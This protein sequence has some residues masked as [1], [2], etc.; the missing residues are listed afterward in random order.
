MGFL[1]SE[2]I[3]LSIDLQYE[4]HNCFFSEC[5]KKVSFGKK[6]EKKNLTRQ[7]AEEFLFLG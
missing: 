4:T 1:Q 2:V 3:Y 5:I 7:Q 6:G